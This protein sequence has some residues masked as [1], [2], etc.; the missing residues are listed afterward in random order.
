LAYYSHPTFDPNRFIGGIPTSYWNELNEDPAKPLIDRVAG[1]GQPAASTWKLA[2][3]GMALGLGVNE[4]DEYMAQPCTGGIY[5]G[6]YARCWLS[7]GNGRQNLIEGIKNSCNVSFY[8][9]GIKIGLER[10]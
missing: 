6:R 9:L 10:I 1:S 7:S 5:Y 3:A 4:P 8:Q 2:V